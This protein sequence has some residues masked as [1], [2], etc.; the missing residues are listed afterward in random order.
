MQGFTKQTAVA[1]TQILFTVEP[2]VSVSIIVDDEGVSVNAEGKK[3]VEAGTPLYGDL[4]ER[5][6]AF[7]TTGSGSPVGV[8][9]HNVD[10]TAG[11]NNGALLIFGF[12]NLNRLSEATA[13]LITSS[14]KTALNG[15]VTFLK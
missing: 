9:L 4:T 7:K 2:K 10:V 1:P 11:D 15:K 6:T 8:A 5:G 13:A 14:V 12:V 3:I